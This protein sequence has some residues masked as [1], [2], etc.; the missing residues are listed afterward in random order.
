MV[1]KESNQTNKQTYLS[2]ADFFKINFLEKILSEM[3]SGCETFW[4]QIRP[5]ILSGLIWV[6][7]VFKRYQQTTVVGKESLLLAGGQLWSTIY[8]RPILDMSREKLS[9][10]LLTRSSS[11][12][13]AQLWRQSKKNKILHATS[14][15]FFTNLFLWVP[16]LT[17]PKFFASQT[18]S[19]ASHTGSTLNYK[20][21]VSIRIRPFIEANLGSKTLVYLFIL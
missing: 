2:S 11:N 12:P 18:R 19:S 13:P 9:S 3:P 5:D 8:I 17:G 6:L 4:I 16:G 7:T 20:F 14:S 1:R 21:C 15:D 10:G